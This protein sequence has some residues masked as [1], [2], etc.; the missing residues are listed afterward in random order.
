MTFS[1]GSVQASAGTHATDTFPLR[2]LQTH[3]AKRLDQL[4]DNVAAVE[5]TLT[6]DEQR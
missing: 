2:K 1:D 6:Q 3:G 4:Q 5:L